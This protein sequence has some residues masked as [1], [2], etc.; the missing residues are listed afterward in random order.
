MNNPVRVIGIDHDDGDREI[1]G[2][3]C[4]WCEE[5]ICDNCGECHNPECIEYEELG[6]YLYLPEW[7][8]N[9]EKERANE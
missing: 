4:Y 9:R 2:G 7:Y 3:Q 6:C 1:Y 8:V 5:D